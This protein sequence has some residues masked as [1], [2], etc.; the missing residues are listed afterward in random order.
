MHPIPF[1]SNSP[2]SFPFKSIIIQDTDELALR[3]MQMLCTSL[4]ST[5]LLPIAYLPIPPYLLISI[6]TRSSLSHPVPP[7]PNPLAS[8]LASM[9]TKIFSPSL[10]PT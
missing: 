8:I 7:L 10:L 9:S 6:Y 2:P 5:S 1:R 3:S 4:P